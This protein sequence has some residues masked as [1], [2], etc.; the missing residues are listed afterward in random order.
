MADYGDFQRGPTYSFSFKIQKLYNLKRKYD[1]RSKSKFHGLTGPKLLTINEFGKK[2]GVSP[3]QLL[4]EPK[5]L[6]IYLLFVK[7]VRCTEPNSSPSGSSN[8]DFRISVFETRFTTFCSN[9]SEF[10]A[11]VLPG[12]SRKGSRE[13]SSRYQ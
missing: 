4:N 8:E 10:F 11:E 5:K 12:K 13:A 1:G 7:G 2:T 6:K 9:R 3:M